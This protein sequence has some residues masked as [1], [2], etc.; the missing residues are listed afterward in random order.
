MNLKGIKK[1]TAF[2]YLVKLQ[3]STEK[4]LKNDKLDSVKT[5]GI[6]AEEELF[7]AYDFTKKL[8]NDLGIHESDID[9]MLFQKIRS[10]KSLDQYEF[11]SEKS[12]K[13]FGKIKDKDLKHFIDRKF[14]ILVNYCSQENVYA[15]IAA[16][17]SKSKMKAGFENEST[18]FYQFVVNISE[19]KINTF[20][21][22]LI[23]YLKILKLIV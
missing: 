1:N 2:K 4:K 9:V 22:E 14:D 12:F 11:F 3:N 21:E 6:L 10:E 7:R 15:H 8:S 19:N 18:S 5:V 16:F 13:M 17:Q 20:N 23:K